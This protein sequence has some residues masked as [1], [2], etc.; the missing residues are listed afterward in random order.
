MGGG[1]VEVARFSGEIRGVKKLRG[2]NTVLLCSKVLLGCPVG[3]R[4][5]VSFYQE[6]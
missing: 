6:L 5:L 2:S 1:G 4:P 3:S